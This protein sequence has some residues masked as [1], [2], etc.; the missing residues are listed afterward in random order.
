MQIATWLRRAGWFGVF[1]LAVLATGTA[2]A[3]DDKP[4]DENSPKA[5]AA[6]AAKE[7]LR[8][9]KAGPHVAKYWLQMQVV[10][11][12]RSLNEQLELKGEGVLVAHVRPDGPADKA[13]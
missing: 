2:K 10:S 7:A 11:V 1:G 8:Q 9:L 12:P 6:A 5:E 3:D 4:A 13:G